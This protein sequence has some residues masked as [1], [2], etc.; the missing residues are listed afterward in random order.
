MTK[1]VISSC[2]QEGGE[3]KWRS[4]WGPRL[5]RSWAINIR[6]AK[7]GPPRP[8]LLA[9]VAKREQF[10]KTWILSDSA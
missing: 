7:Q 1:K 5:G 8:S 9:I 2:S 10:W 4:T 3:G 6:D